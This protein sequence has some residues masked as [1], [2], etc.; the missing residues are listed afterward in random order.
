MSLISQRGQLMPESPIRKLVPFADQAKK[1]GKKIYHLNIG[2]PD[3]ET[4]AGVLQKVRSFD[5]KVI[6]YSNSLGNLS[7]REKWAAYYQNL[8]YDI[9]AK[10]MVITTGGSEALMFAFMSCFD[11]GDEVI[12]PEPYYANYNGF[13]VSCGL[14]VKTVTCSIENGFALPPMAEIEKKIGPKTKGILI[15]NPGN[16]TGTVY[17]AAELKEL[18]GIVQKYPLVLIADEVYREFCYDGKTHTSVLSFPE[19]LEQVIVID[20]LSKRYS[21]CGAR[22]GALV[23]CNAQIMQTATKFAQARLS[24]PTMAQVMGE[25]A[26]NTPPSYME[27]VMVE[28][29]TRRDVLVQRL[30]A[31]PGVQCPKP[32]GAF[33]AVAQLPVDDAD[34]FCQWLL[35]DFDLNGETVMLAPASGFYENPGLGKKQVRI[36]YVLEV[37]ELNKAMDCLQEALKQ[38][39][40]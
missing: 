1:Q 7:L 37:S 12:I 33:Y 28:Y 31:M 38:Y 39:T 3:I 18:A 23:T 14:V 17:S 2:Q 35:E 20:S 30:N 16:P 27:K 15:C 26:M 8:G 13:A 19:I 40:S 10:D 21:M 24:P 29:Q 4:P 34:R 9:Q 11:S 5:A 25:E 36:A 22:L 6:E 32:G